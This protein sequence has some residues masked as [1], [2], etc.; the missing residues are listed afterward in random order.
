V[1]LQT[2]ASIEWAKGD[3]NAAKATMEKAVAVAEQQNWGEDELSKI[4]AMRDR[5]RAGQ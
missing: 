3:R 2:L 5:Y 4:R 1:A